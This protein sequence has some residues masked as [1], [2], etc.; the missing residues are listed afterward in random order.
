MK[1][2]I[3]M[4]NAYIVLDA[5]DSWHL[6]GERSG[7]VALQALTDQAV[8]INDMILRLYLDCGRGSQVRMLIKYRPYRRCN[9]LVVGTTVKPTFPFCRAPIK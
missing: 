5:S 4:R 7:G 1:F 2:F 6:T 9:L 8:Q 3:L